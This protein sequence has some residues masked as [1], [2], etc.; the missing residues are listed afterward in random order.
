MQFPLQKQGNPARD[1]TGHLRESNRNSL[2]QALDIQRITHQSAL[3]L[4]SIF[5]QTEDS[6]LK[7]KLA[8]VISALGKTWV[9]LQDSKREI[10]GKPK[11]GS[12]RPTGIKTRGWKTVGAGQRSIAPI[13]LSGSTQPIPQAN[14]QAQ[15]QPNPEPVQACPA[16]LDPE[17]EAKPITF[18][19]L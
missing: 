7:S 2:G 5:V 9:A 3:T 15:P 19:L 10:L 12:L 8:T 1:K 11:A 18:E 4:Q 17:P 14:A 6:N 13:L 16:C